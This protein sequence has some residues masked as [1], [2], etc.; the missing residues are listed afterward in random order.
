MVGSPS[1]LSAISGGDLVR[2]VGDQLPRRRV[3]RRERERQCI[4]QR[5]LDVVVPRQPLAEVRLEA[6]VELHG[7]YEAHALSEVGG[8]DAESRADLEHDVVPLQVGEA[9]GDA[10]DVLVD[11]EVLAELAVGRDGELH[12]RPNAAVAF[13]SITRSSSSGASPRA[14]ASTASVWITLAGSFGRPR[15]A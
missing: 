15:T 3:E 10:E 2:Q 14:S 11:Q 12:G 9:A 7:V 5:E 4:A 8:E 1:R 6:A 13:A